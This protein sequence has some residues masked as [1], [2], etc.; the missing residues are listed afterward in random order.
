MNYF[1]E[2]SR[3]QSQSKIM[4]VA[5]TVITRREKER[6]VLKIGTCKVLRNLSNY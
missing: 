2:L 5:V 4:D 3:I 6:H 1:P